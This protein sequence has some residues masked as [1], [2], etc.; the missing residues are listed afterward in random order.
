MKYIKLLIVT[1]IAAF[2]LMQSTYSAVN[3]IQHIKT[4]PYGDVRFTLDFNLLNTVKNLSHIRVAYDR[5]GTV[6]VEGVAIRVDKKNSRTIVITPPLEGWTP[7]SEYYLFID[8]NAIKTDKKKIGKTIVKSFISLD[9][10]YRTISGEVKLNKMKAFF[11][12]LTVKVRAVHYDIP[13]QVFE[14]EAL[15]KKDSTRTKYSIKVPIIPS[16]YHVEYEINSQD[17]YMHIA[18]EYLVPFG[19]VSNSNFSSTNYQARKKVH[20]KSDIKQNIDIIINDKTVDK[21]ISIL[22]QI[23]KPGMSD[24]EKEVAIYKYVIRNI[25]YPEAS[26]LPNDEKYRN[27][28]IY[29]ALFE[30][31]AICVGY[32]F[33][34]DL[35]LK[36]VGIESYVE[37]SDSLMHNWNIVK[38]DGKYYHLDATRR[39]LLFLNFPDEFSNSEYNVPDRIKKEFRCTNYDYNYI[40]YHYWKEKQIEF[41][42]KVEVSGTVSLP[43]GEK[44]PKG[45]S[46]VQILF[47]TEDSKFYNFVTVTIPEGK[48]SANY[49]IIVVPTNDR[50]I[51]ESQLSND[52]TVQYKEGS[53]TIKNDSAY[54]IELAKANP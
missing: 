3:G 20:V 2:L 50:Y 27:N 7:K 13:S 24:F 19:Y 17:Q 21:V 33:L 42:K 41:G 44:A 43:E 18:K 45:G 46:A 34:M 16:G 47:R 6:P 5:N 35:L 26:K 4:K 51:I 36:S 8:K 38:L 37:G 49:S 54:N 11:G 22:S 15:I 39:N 48:R 32:A 53:I 14:C 40:F 25:V 23:I 28:P 52:T 29:T 9:Y 1:L 30:K 10:D 12:D 31:E